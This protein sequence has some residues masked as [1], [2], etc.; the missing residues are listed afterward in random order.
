MK[1][2]FTLVLTMVTMLSASAQSAADFEVGENVAAKLGLGDVDGQSFSGQTSA[3][4]DTNRPHDKVVE[5]MGNYWKVDGDMPN[6]FL[7]AYDGNIGIYGFY[8]KKTA[9]MYQVVKFPAGAY[10]VT[11]QAL[12][13]EGTP[14]DNFT[15][16]FNKK[17]TKYGHLYADCLTS[18]DPSS[19]VTRNFDKVL[20]TLATADQ[21]EEVYRYDDSSWMNDYKYDLK[22]KET[23]EVTSYYCPQCLDGL[24]RYFGLGKYVNTMKIVVTEDTY[25]RLGFRK[26]G[27]ITAD[28]LVFTNL[29]VTYDGPASDEQKIELAQEEALAALS[30]L[31]DIQND[32]LTIGYDAL[33]GIIG[34]MIMEQFQDPIDEGKDVE[35]V[36]AAK[37][38]INETI[39]KYSP[40]YQFA[41][42]LSVLLTSCQA[43]I[44]STDLDGK[45]IFQAA[46][47]KAEKE[48]MTDD[49]EA[50]GDNPSAYYQKIY[51]E[52]SKAR[53]DYLNTQPKDEKGS[54]DF[55]SL[56][57]NPWFVN[58]EYNPT[59]NDDGSWTLKEGGWSDWGKVCAKGSPKAYNQVDRAGLELADICSDVV[60]YPSDDVTNE[61][62]KAN[63]YT[64]GWSAGVGL[65]YQSGLV[66]VSDG[67]NSLAVG[68]I[69]IEQRLVGLPK[70]YYSLKALVRGNNGDNTWDGKNREIYAKNSSGEFVVSETVKNDSDRPGASQQYGWY[71]WNPN[72]WADVETSIISALDGELTIGGRC[73]KVANFTGFRLY[74]YGESLDFTSKLQE[75]IDKIQPEAEALSFLGDKNKAME[76]I[77]AITATFPLPDNDA[78][79][80][81][82]AK[83]VEARDYI[84]N[85]AAVEKKYTAFETISNLTD[86]DFVM[87]AVEYMMSYGEGANDTYEK[88]DE[89]NEIAR[90][91]TIYCETYEKAVAL[92]DASVNAILEGQVAEIKTEMKD[93]DTMGTYLD[94]LAVPY[95]IAV[96]ASAGAAD[97]TEANPTNVTSFIVNP[98]F[99]NDPTS[100]WS[101]ETPTNNE[102]AFDTDGNKVN[103][104][105]WN[106]SAFTLSQTI[107]GLPAGTYELRVQAIYRDGGAVNQELVDA[108]KEAGNEEAWAN[109]N[110]QLFMKTSDEN[111]KFTYI[112][113]IE[114]LN[115]TENSFTEVV[116]AWG[117]D[118][119]ADGNVVTYAE[120]AVAI[121]GTT[122]TYDGDIYGN[123]VTEGSYPFDTK[124]GD[125]YYPSS[126]QGFLQVCK[127]HPADVTN[128]VQITIEQSEPLQIGIRK[129]AAIGSDWVIFDKFEL[130]YISGD[131]FKQILT[132]IVDVKPV[133]TNSVKYN[134]AGQRV[135]N[136][137]KGIVISNGKKQFVK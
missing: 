62:Y 54:K 11:V 123:D 72:A 27:A 44:A 6:E 67:W 45:D 47:E 99:T 9:D 116:T 40:V 20:C 61:W 38:A 63:R 64:S 104:E 22:D 8:D 106:K 124:V 57:K 14:A 16:H 36:V 55:T 127:K 114:S 43:V 87:P 5:T 46:Y 125:N 133:S 50:L 77:E 31:Q 37:N 94:Q 126:M 76:M 83:Y 68:T 41:K 18:S 102:Y 81:A 1:K 29:Q 107:T 85:A 42:N 135:A 112:K 70:G 49:V 95:N 103:A 105:L 75:Y 19:E 15:N 130:Y 80:V 2:L 39:D 108:Y 120:K 92:N 90:V 53:A 32:F 117:S 28:W 7:E 60:L 33:Y 23:G 88:V 131:T 109:H 66:G 26:T 84:L 111:D 12:Y 58:V 115:Y 73:S 96:M 129:T 86:Y 119:D 93:A 118:E 97:A 17:Y 101:G 137:Y 24:S 52:L 98:E 3:N 132:D 128:K 71:E 121:E 136:S 51:N 59:Q 65:M 74:F 79:E 89:L 134:V 110:A 56:V 21:H 78:Y 82:Y 100:G 91:Y 25:I 122:K 69:G 113:A 30:N 48:A 35:S 4:S 13:R 10:T 34:D